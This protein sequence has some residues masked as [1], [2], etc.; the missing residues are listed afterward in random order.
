VIDPLLAS[1][2]L[3]GGGDED[4][5][6][7]TL[8]SSGDVYIAGK[9][10][11]SDF[12]TTPGAYDESLNGFWD[13]YI[14]KLD[15]NLATLSASTFLGGDEDDIGYSII[16]DT[17]GNVYV[18]G[19][20]ESSD[21]PTTP[22]AYDETYDSSDAYITKLDGNLSTLLASTF[23]GGSTGDWG[24]SITLDN[25]GNVYAIGETRSSDFPTTP[26]AY[27]ESYNGGVGGGDVYISKL[28][29]D[30]SYDPPFIQIL[31]PDGVDDIVDTSFVIT[32]IDGCPNDDATISLYH[33]ID[34][35]GEDGTLIISGI[36]EDDSTDQYIWD[37]SAMPEGDYFIYGLIDDGSTSMAYYTDVTINNKILI[38]DSKNA[39]DL[40][41][42]INTNQNRSTRD[43]E[44]TYDDFESGWGNWLDG[45]GDCSRYTSGH[46]AC[47]GNAAINIQD[48]SFGSSFML[49]FPIDVD[50][51]G[52]TEIVV[53][54]CFYANNLENG[55]GFLVQYYDGSIWRTVADLYQ[56]IDFVGNV[57]NFE[58]VT[59]RE[60]DYAFP[61]DMRIRFMCDASSNT[62]D[63]YIDDIRISAAIQE[64]ISDYSDGPL[65]ID[66]NDA[67]AIQIIEPDGVTDV[68]DTSYTI[69]WTDDDPD[70]D[71]TIS[72]FYD[73]DDTGEDGTLIIS[74]IS[75]DDEADLYEWDTS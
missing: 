66:H 32:W 71:A 35:S 24:N 57:F 43:V 2:F 50:A 49:A 39:L 48:N 60:A 10:S 31:Q 14:T 9:T 33:D 19:I 15:V 18:T 72:L 68:A 8:G 69:T 4:G 67:P 29:G 47:Q 16:L 46:F 75:E 22:G 7:I 28:D 54:F 25:S 59:I 27:D 36:S 44:L 11:S 13:A 51:P 61:Q 12:P 20:T 70:D 41:D 37:T 17:D 3:G 53:E 56:G 73:T 74:G 63:I 42:Q 34:N 21:F 40:A 30:L 65:T 23:L 1:T 55:E 45:G 26:G 58:T 52:Y 38:D 64:S 6:S 5:L 62:D